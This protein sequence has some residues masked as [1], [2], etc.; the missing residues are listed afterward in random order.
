MAAALTWGGPYF[1]FE[2]N[3][4]LP[5]NIA[6]QGYSH[7]L[8]NWIYELLYPQPCST[9][10]SFLRDH[11]QLCG[12]SAAPGGSPPSG[13]RNAAAPKRYPAA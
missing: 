11:L 2:V 3:F 13:N 9:L 5:A 6:P 4:A 1:K 8:S 10:A 12:P 7:A